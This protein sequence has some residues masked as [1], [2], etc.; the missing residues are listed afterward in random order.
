MATEPLTNERVKISFDL[1]PEDQQGYSTE[2]VWAER[3]GPDEFRILNSPFFV[4]GVSADD[5][6]KV[7]LENGEQKFEHVARKGGHSTYRVFI[8]GGRTLHVEDF[9]SRWA[10][11]QALGATFENANDRLLSVDVGSG[12]DIVR[13]YDLLKQGEVDGI[14]AFEEGNYEGTT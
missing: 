4:F 9:R 14:W 11:I 13:V 8:Q 12:V 6:V 1:R 3:V 5:V 10:A 7:K 2:G